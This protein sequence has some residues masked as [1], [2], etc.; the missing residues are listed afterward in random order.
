M[1]D[2]LTVPA[3]L[4][5]VG[6]LLVFSLAGKGATY[7]PHSSEAAVVGGRICSSVVSEPL[8]YRLLYLFYGVLLPPY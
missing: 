1:V 7:V 8:Q 4:L 3:C 6:L 5:L 2:T